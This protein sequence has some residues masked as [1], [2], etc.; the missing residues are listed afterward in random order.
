MYRTLNS[1]AH[2]FN[3]SKTVSIYPIGDFWRNNPLSEDT[4][5]FPRQAG[6]RP[7]PEYIREKTVNPYIDT[8]NVYQKPC[9]IIMPVSTCYLQKKQ[10]TTQP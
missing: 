8:C 7:Y 2:P 4:L 6:Y 3:E 1:V 9:D 5:I 10:I